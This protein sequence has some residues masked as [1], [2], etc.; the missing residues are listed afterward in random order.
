MDDAELY[1]LPR[2]IREEMARARLLAN[3]RNRGR[4]RVQV[5][6][7]WYPIASFD[8]TGF[9]VARDAAPKLRGLVEIHDGARMVRSALIVA[10]APDGD[11]IRYDYKRATA[12]RTTP[13]VD[14]VRSVDAPAG[15]LTGA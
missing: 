11:V 2:E 13:P 4:L 7:D 12:V 9:E 8:A 14:Y 6:E 10:S 3:R 1:H 15:Y 5:G